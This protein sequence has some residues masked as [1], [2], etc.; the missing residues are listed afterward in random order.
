MTGLKENQLESLKQYIKKLGPVIVAFSGGVDSTLVL[1]AA[2]QALGKEKVVAITASSARGGIS[3]YHRG[4]S[5][6]RLGRLS[7]RTQSA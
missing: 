6:R 7:A 5:C 3:Y 1:V 4:Y 2:I